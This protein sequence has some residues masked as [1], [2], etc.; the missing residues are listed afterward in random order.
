LEAD[1]E[2]MEQQLNRPFAQAQLRNA[3]ERL[4]LKEKI[5]PEGSGK[6]SWLRAVDGGI[7][8]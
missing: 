2:K 7:D 6:N 3:I 5:V 4:E 1:R 8:A